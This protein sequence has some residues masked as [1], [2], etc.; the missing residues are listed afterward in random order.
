MFAEIEE[1]WADELGED[2]VKGLREAAERIAELE[3]S[4][5]RAGARVA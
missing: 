3:G 1:E 5:A 4:P 2:L